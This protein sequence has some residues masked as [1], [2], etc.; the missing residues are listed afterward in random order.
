MDIIRSEKTPRKWEWIAQQL[1]KHEGLDK[2]VAIAEQIDTHLRD[3]Y[4]EHTHVADWILDMRVWRGD[5]NIVN[6]MALV[7][8]WTNCTACIYATAKRKTDYP[9][10]EIAVKYFKC[11]FCEFAKISGACVDRYEVDPQPLYKQFIDAMME[12]QAK[13][14][15]KQAT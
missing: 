1:K 15:D 6:I 7:V 8:K 5:S 13:K 3:I 14:V 2:A 11:G 4:G 12:W 10:A 9:D